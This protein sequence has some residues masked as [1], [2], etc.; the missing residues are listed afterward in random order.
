MK[1][2][3]CKILSVMLTVCLLFGSLA[4]LSQAK[5]DG[6]VLT[7]NDARAILRASVGIDKITD[8]DDLKLADMNFDSKLTVDDARA[9]LRLSVR[10]DVIDGKTYNNEYEALA[11][12]HY[13]IS[14]TYTENDPKDG[15]HSGSLIVSKTER[16]MKLDIGGLLEMAGMDT[17]EMMEMLGAFDGFT[18][19]S[20]LFSNNKISICSDSSKESISMNASAFGDDFNEVQK[21]MNSFIPALHGSLS[22]ANSKKS[23]TYN[24]KSCTVYVFNEKDEKGTN[25]TANVYMSGKKLVKID[26][27]TTAGYVFKSLVV[28]SFSRAVAASDITLNG[29]EDI[30]ASDFLK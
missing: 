14:A 7:V 3:S 9:V 1:K 8:A 29:Y 4:A 21:E 10:L 16:T 27:A 23:A 24:G 12:G 20:I 22:Q 28:K 6:Y 2:F 19:S 5:M 26:Y 15:S 30:D 13:V 17:K 25:Y 11:S 18:P